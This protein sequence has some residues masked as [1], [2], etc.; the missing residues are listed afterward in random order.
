[1]RIFHLLNPSI[2]LF[3]SLYLSIL[4]NCSPLQGFSC[5]S[6]IDCPSSHFCSQ[7]WCL[8]K[9]KNPNP[10]P[11]CPDPHKILLSKPS[12]LSQHH[13]N[14]EGMVSDNTFLYWTDSKRGTIS[15]RKIPNGQEEILLKSLGRVSSIILDEKYIFATIRS[16]APQLPFGA[17]IRLPKTGALQPTILA[18]NLDNPKDI[19]VDKHFVYWN[20][21]GYTKE[22]KIMKI[23]KNYAAMP[24]TL[25]KAYQIYSIALDQQALYW[26]TFSDS[27]E[28]WKLD[29]S[30]NALH[31]LGKN[32]V[33]TFD[34][35]VSDEF[36]YYLNQTLWWKTKPNG[37]IFKLSRA[38]DNAHQMVLDD[39]FVF[40]AT[41]HEIFQIAR[42][43]EHQLIKTPDISDIGEIS[44]IAVDENYLY[45]AIRSKNIFADK[46]YIMKKN[47]VK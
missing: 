11:T 32:L 45:L 42:K 16:P 24:T 22:G 13:Q 36:I 41:N 27:G 44:S 20:S 5:R 12:L 9:K 7:G 43:C 46:I 8:L 3:L 28:L 15:R 40:V 25:I 23:P 17:I 1:M 14:I 29:T 38:L 33:Y 34:L 2:F 19:V 4:F 10:S 47:E 21:V 6:N 31:N 35:A 30:N 26:L 39:S 18:R 37:R